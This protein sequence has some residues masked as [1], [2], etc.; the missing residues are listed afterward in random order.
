MKRT[1]LLVDLDGGLVV[2]DSD[3][4]TNETVLADFDLDFLVWRI[5]CWR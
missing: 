4:F 2:V 3:D 1:R 5:E